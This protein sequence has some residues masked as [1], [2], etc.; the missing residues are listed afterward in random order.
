MKTKN[1]IRTL[2]TISLLITFLL[3]YF[4]DL[5]GL[6]LHQYL[7]VAAALIA[8]FHLITHWNWVRSV[9]VRL[10]S[11][12]SL[13]PKLYYVLDLSLFLG[14]VVITITGILISTWLA[15]TAMNRR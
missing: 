5:T 15:P 14:L 6:E 7:G 11:K 12:V 8:I 13:R 2:A 1:R 9:T 10:F 3:T 4:M